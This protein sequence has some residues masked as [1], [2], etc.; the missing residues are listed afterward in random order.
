[1]P[2]FSKDN[3]HHAYLLLGGR[4]EGLA[5]FGQVLEALEFKIAGNPDY[6]AFEGEVL[7]I[8]EARELSR[9]AVMKSFGERKLFYLAPGKFTVEAENALLKL[10]EEPPENTHFFIS[11]RE[12]EL[13]LPT[14]LSRL[15][16]VQAGS[17][18]SRNVSAA[19]K[20][21]AMP[22][23]ERI[24]FAREFADSEAS[25]SVF[26]DELLLRMRE[27]GVGTDK[28]EKVF[29][30]RKFADDRSVMPRLMLE[31]LSLII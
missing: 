29:R 22:P 18:L 7:G 30:V 5:V 12:K 11:A 10:L 25:L 16:V 20:F 14:L 23:G 6:F 19:G 9:R 21:L 3:L 4:E 17:E 1:M 28:L 27:N 15:K 2:E 13:F 31:H 24:A 8:D 26:L